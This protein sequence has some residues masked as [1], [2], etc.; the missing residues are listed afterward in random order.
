[1]CVKVQLIASELSLVFFPF[2]FSFSLI[3]FAAL[4]IFC[5][6]YA[7]SLSHD[8]ARSLCCNVM[9]TD[10]FSTVVAD[11]EVFLS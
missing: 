8:L 11:A 6:V 10:S 1:M 4:E 2:V 3:K 9:S 7:S 5:L